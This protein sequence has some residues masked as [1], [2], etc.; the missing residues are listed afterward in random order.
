MRIITHFRGESKRIQC[1][2]E[3]FPRPASS[4]AFRGRAE[5]ASA[6]MPV[7]QFAW[8]CAGN[9]FPPV[10]L[11]S[12]CRLTHSMRAVSILANFPKGGPPPGLPSS[13]RRNGERSRYEPPAARSPLGHQGRTKCE[14]P[15]CRPG[16]TI[17][18]E[19][20]L[21]RCL[22]GEPTGKPR[23]QTRPPWP[24]AKAQ[25]AHGAPLHYDYRC[26][27][28]ESGH[29]SAPHLEGVR[30]ETRN[31]ST[32]DHEAYHFMNTESYERFHPR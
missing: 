28:R 23:Q 4:L 8:E 12:F 13:L 11:R 14:R 9:L 21:I 20:E 15:Q 17:R 10:H 1:G 25:L 22:G 5:P 29:R 32:S 16:D 24:H 26:P 30:S 27:P 6:I 31:I 18:H 2:F 7:L 3:T 19:G